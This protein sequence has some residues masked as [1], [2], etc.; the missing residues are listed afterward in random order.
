MF[1]AHM[2]EKDKLTKA[3][4]FVNYPLHTLQRVL[5]QKNVKFMGEAMK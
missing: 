1:T 2:R 4:N 5:A 3:S